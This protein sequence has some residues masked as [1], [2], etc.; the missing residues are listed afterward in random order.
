MKFDFESLSTE[1]LFYMLMHSGAFVGVVGAVFFII[2]LLFGYATWGRYKRQTRELRGE[3]DAMKDEIA[4]LKRKIGDQSVKSGQAIA[5]ATETIHMPPKEAPAKPDAPAATISESPAVD[6]TE[7][8]RAATK[9]RL[10]QP[11][12]INT[13]TPKVVVTEAAVPPAK[14]EAPVA[15]AAAAKPITTSIPLPPATEP[16]PPPAPARHSSPLAAI[17]AAPPPEKKE[18]D[19]KS[20][21]ASTGLVPAD[22]I[23]TMTAELPV[24]AVPAVAQPVLDPRLGLIYKT[25]PEKIDDLTALKGIA[26]VLEERLHEFGIYTYAQIA[27]WSEDQIKEFSSRLAFKDRIQRERWVEQAQQLLAKKTH[28]ST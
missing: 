4:Q 9:S 7:A 5:M 11:P 25:K 2:G 8:R 19:E 10:P 21:A 6:T 3:A 27:S 15:P 1:P 23:P 14:P 17:V 13:I 12:R 18:G 16:P 24:T 28:S 20:D 22:T 26:Q